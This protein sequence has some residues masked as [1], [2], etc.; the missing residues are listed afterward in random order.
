VKNPF[1]PVTHPPTVRK[2]AKELMLYQT[3]FFSGAN[4]PNL[5][6]K[7]KGVSQLF[8]LPSFTP[9]QVWLTPLVEDGQ[10]TYI[11]NLKN[12]CFKIFVVPKL[13]R[14]LPILGRFLFKITLKKGNLQ[15]FQLPTS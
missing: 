6:R 1:V 14:F 12:V 3:S 13:L 7:K 9:H 4:F 10:P 8:S 5:P 15:F 2:F 11:T